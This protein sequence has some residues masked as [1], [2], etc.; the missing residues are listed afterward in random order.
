MG[1]RTDRRNFG[2]VWRNFKDLW[3]KFWPFAPVD[4]LNAVVYQVED[5][6]RTLIIHI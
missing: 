4:A 2:K 1:A 5:L 3:R 6:W